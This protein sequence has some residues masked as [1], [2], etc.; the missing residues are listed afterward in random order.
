MILQVNLLHVLPISHLPPNMFMPDL[1]PLPSLSPCDKKH[2]HPFPLVSPFPSLVLPQT[3]PQGSSNDA[4]L[5]SHLASLPVL[6]RAYH[7]CIAAFIFVTRYI[8]HPKTV[9]FFLFC[10]SPLS[11]CAVGPQIFC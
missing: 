9:I 2:S 4:L 3:L 6:Y 7:S 1:S 8:L 5:T 10:S 11:Q